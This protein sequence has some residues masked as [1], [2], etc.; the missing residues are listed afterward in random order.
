MCLHSLSVAGEGGWEKR[1]AQ[2]LQFGSYSLLCTKVQSG[3]EKPQGPKAQV[4]GM[5]GPCGGKGPSSGTSLRDGPGR[6]STFQ[7]PQSKT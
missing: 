4:N 7:H 2:T 5:A 1:G 3:K 6:P